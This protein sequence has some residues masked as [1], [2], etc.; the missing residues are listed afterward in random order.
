MWRTIVFGLIAAAVLAGAIWYGNS[1]SPLS[2]QNEPGSKIVNTNNMEALKIEDVVAGAGTEARSGDTVTVHYTGTLTDGSTFDSS[3]DRGV[4]FVFTLGGGQVI[5]GW[6]EGL[7]GMRVGGTRKLTIAPEFG[8][9][10]QGIGP[11]PPNS[12]LLF[13]IELLEVRKGN[14]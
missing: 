13:E 11:I 4:P 7:L 3:V 2:L 8:Y 5:R 9:G 14:Q 6:D 1:N 10:S 12:T